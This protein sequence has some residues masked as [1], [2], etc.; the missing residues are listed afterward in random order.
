M[1]VST[2]HQISNTIVI[3]IENLIRINQTLIFS[4]QSNPD[5]FFF[6][7]TLMENFQPDP[8]FLNSDAIVI[9]IETHGRIDRILIFILRALRG[10]LP[11]VFRTPGHPGHA[12]SSGTASCWTAGADSSPAPLAV[13]TSPFSAPVFSGGF[14]KK[15][16]RM[17]NGRR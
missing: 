13:S 5:E 4:I 2:E 12:S 10:K 7:Q 17:T 3:A 15:I 1:L 11:A 14:R 16:P 9:A 8:D 6:L